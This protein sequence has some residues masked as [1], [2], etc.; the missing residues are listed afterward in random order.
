M[1]GQMSVMQGQVRVV[2]LLV[3]TRPLWVHLSPPTWPPTQFIPLCVMCMCYVFLCRVCMCVSVLCV[4]RCYVYCVYTVLPRHNGGDFYLA[5]PQQLTLTNWRFAIG[6]SLTII[7]LI[8]GRN[9]IPGAW[10]WLLEIT[11]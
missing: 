4:C 3:Y 10:A 6:G 2:V 7:I 8:I 1:R 11:S 9:I 5:E